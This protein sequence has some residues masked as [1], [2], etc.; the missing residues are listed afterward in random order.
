MNIDPTLLQVI[1]ATIGGLFIITCG[2]VGYVSKN[3]FQ[4]FRD[5]NHNI[6]GLNKILFAMK[7]ELSTSISQT[8]EWVLTDFVSKEEH[9]RIC[10]K[11]KR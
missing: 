6:E 10:P 2:A 1:L 4:Q 8:R 3:A 9:D 5:L 7:E 11:V